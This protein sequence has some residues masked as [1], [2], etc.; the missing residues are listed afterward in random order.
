MWTLEFVSTLRLRSNRIHVLSMRLADSFNLINVRLVVS[1]WQPL[2]GYD[3]IR[4]QQ[5]NT[6]NCQY[7]VYTS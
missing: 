5:P 4:L 3:R 7:E 1:R 6:H 2:I